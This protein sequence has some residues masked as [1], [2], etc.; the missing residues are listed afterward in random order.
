MAREQ[1][2]N[3]RE[4]RGV[5]GRL[6]HVKAG[7]AVDVNVNKARRENS[8][9]KSQRLDPAGK[10]ERILRAERK[11]LSVFDDDERL[12]NLLKR[13]E[14]GGGG[15]GYLHGRRCSDTQGGTPSCKVSGISSLAIFGLQVPG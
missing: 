10:L 15:D 12:A 1:R 4:S 9:R 7:A 8:V 13:C 6:H 11:Y 5:I 3:R 14:Q 2:F